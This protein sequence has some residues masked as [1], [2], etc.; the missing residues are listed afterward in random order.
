MG[1]AK[2]GRRSWC[3]DHLHRWMGYRTTWTGIDPEN[4]LGIRYSTS[5]QAASLPSCHVSLLLGY[6]LCLTWCAVQRIALQQQ[7]GSISQWIN[8][9]VPV[10]ARASSSGGL[11][12]EPLRARRRREIR[13][14][15]AWALEGTHWTDRCIHRMHRATYLQRR[16]PSKNCTYIHIWSKCSHTYHSNVCMF[17]EIPISS[18]LYPVSLVYHLSRILLRHLL[19]ARM[20]SDH[21]IRANRAGRRSNDKGSIHKNRDEK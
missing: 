17:L 4:R 10:A 19:F 5:L 21:W 15:P 20:G 3:L 6:I 1:L 12:E 14:R 16:P 18:T 13:A 11:V 8:G 2:S 7:P 9:I